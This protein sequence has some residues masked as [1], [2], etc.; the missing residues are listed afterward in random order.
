[1]SL[2][3]TVEQRP[4]WLIC[5]ATRMELE[6]FWNAGEMP[7]LERPDFLAWHSGDA[8]AVTGVGIPFTFARLLPLA[9]RLQPKRILNIGIAG[10]YPNS[11]FKI[12]DIVM[13][14]VEVY[15][16]LGFELPSE[17]AGA[18]PGFQSLVSS[19]MGKQMDA[20]SFDLLHASE[21]IAEPDGYALHT[22]LIGATV[23]ACTGTEHTGLIR[24]SLFSAAYET[25]EGAAVAHVGFLL[26]I[27]VCEVRAISNIAARRDM[28]PEN[29]Q[30][31]LANLRHYLGQW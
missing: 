4:E 29:I 3:E 13:G 26:G 16:D 30:L 20:T 1:M 14:R 10:A 22:G 6:T 21:W 23:N 24:E 28:R 17:S 25:M 12:G 11:G 5:A 15:G 18:E 9:Q 7:P 19:V 27:P 31:A 2:I 8:C